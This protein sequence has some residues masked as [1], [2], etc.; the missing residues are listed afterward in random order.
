[1]DAPPSV[2]FRTPNQNPFI[3]S[4]LSVQSSPAS[5][6]VPSK[7][8]KNFLPPSS[9]RYVRLV[10]NSVFVEP[11][12]LGNRCSPRAVILLK[13][14][15]SL[16]LAWFLIMASYATQPRGLC[17]IDVIFFSF[18]DGPIGRLR[19]VSLFCPPM[20]LSKGTLKPCWV[21]II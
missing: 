6:R 4:V 3:P 17:T 11:S 8:W 1:M 12:R 9:R 19:E 13:I 15:L 5:G 14:L 10:Q 20:N 21:G 7:P 18:Q 2:W 16:E